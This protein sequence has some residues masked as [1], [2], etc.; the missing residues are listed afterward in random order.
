MERKKS[1]E[2]TIQQRSTRV[3]NQQTQRR[4]R[5]KKTKNKKESGTR[6]QNKEENR[7]NTKSQ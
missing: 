7:T 1:K 3:K 4:T 5:L 2:Q 6:M